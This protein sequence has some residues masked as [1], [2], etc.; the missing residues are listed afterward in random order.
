VK[1]T[2]AHDVLAF[3][4]AWYRTR[5]QLLI[6]PANMALSLPEVGAGESA[7]E[8]RRAASSRTRFVL[9]WSTN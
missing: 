1:P 7:A 9:H 8:L 5:A 4:L 6:V 2:V 3:G